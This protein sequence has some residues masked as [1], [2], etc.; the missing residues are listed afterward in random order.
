[1]LTFEVVTLFPQLFT[2]NLKELPFKKAIDKNLIKVNLHNLRDFALDKHGTVDA[3][4]YGGGVGMLL[5]IE[6]LYKILHKI[7]KTS[8]NEQVDLKKLKTGE[9]TRILVMAPSGEKLTQKKVDELVNLEKVVIVCGR[10]EG[11]DARIE[12]IADVEYVS[13]G[14]YVLSG[15]ELP[16]LVI[17]ESITRTLP[18][19][20]EK[21]EAAALESFRNGTLEHP[22]YTRPENFKGWKVPEVLLSGHHKNIEDWKSENSK[23]I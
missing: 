21:D 6:P 16:A 18:G 4:P 10:Y 5:M 15:G 9:K 11:M 2:N 1:M 12:E 19:V 17:M 13:I 7:F 14:D 23:Q 20:L 8:E 3:K 22:Q